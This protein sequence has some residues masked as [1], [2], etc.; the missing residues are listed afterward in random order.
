ML[1][2]TFRIFFTVQET[3]QMLLAIRIDV[4]VLESIG[5]ECLNVF[6]CLIVVELVVIEWGWVF[7]SNTFE[8]NVEMIFFCFEAG[9]KVPEV[10]GVDCM[11]LC[12]R[13]AI[14][15]QLHTL[16]APAVPKISD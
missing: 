11:A 6:E 7:E 5:L 4:W 1:K 16:Q 2:R 12:I 3:L 10:I 9:I 13:C 15:M 14:Q 8:S